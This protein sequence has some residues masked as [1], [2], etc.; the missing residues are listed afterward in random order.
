MDREAWRA[1]IHGVAKSQT[2]LG[3]C[4]E[5]NWT[6]QTIYRNSRDFSH[7]NNHWESLE[8]RTCSGLCGGNCIYENNTLPT[9]KGNTTLNFRICK[10]WEG[11]SLL[12]C[13]VILESFLEEVTFGPGSEA[14]GPG[15]KVLKGWELVWQ[16]ESG[17]F[18]GP[19]S[20]SGDWVNKQL[21]GKA[22]LFIFLYIAIDKNDLWSTFSAVT[23]KP[24][25]LCLTLCDP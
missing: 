21:K 25:Q 20:R 2:W 10:C 11:K 3:N 4:T 13:G 23:A 14:E 5:L 16:D 18:P 8:F 7:S 15:A 9:L 22:V 12:G 1:V 17:T 19:Q 24:L 6:E